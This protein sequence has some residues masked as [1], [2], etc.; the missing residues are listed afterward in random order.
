MIGA[1]IAGA[2]ASGAASNMG[3]IL[4]NRSNNR[5][6]KWATDV[7]VQEA[8]NN[9]AFQE[10]MSNT[11]VQR[12]MADLSA[13][14]INP[15]LAGTY[16][17]STPA[18]AMAQA[19]TYHAENPLA[20]GVNSALDVM[21]LGNESDLVDAQVDKMAAETGKTRA[22]IIKVG[23]E[24][25]QINQLTSL[26]AAKT[27]LTD[28]LWTKE[29]LEIEKAMIYLGW[30]DIEDDLYQEYPQLKEMEVLGRSGT[31]VGMA[32]GAAAGVGYGVKAFLK[33]V[34]KNAP[35]S[36]AQFKQ[37]LNKYLH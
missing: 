17:A 10:R 22:E 29:G 15:I 31:A 16:D 24:V 37:L 36:W 32:A 27:A 4:Q 7:N 1:I 18:G 21:R 26:E 23:A 8:A 2:I 19:Q 6:A 28:R 5:I 3:T 11:A 20:G 14:G 25:Q 34:V 9:R 13:A 33:A 35:K 30:L 12:R